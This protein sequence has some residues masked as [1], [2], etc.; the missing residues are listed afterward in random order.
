[1]HLLLTDRLT[2]P[3]CGPRFGLILRADRLDDRRVLEGVLGCPNCREAYPVRE[4]TGDLRPEPRSTVPDVPDPDPAADDE[5]MAARALLGLGAEIGLTSG[6]AQVVLT[7]GVAELAPGLAAHLEDLEVV[8]VSFGG[9]GVGS[10]SGERPWSRVLTTG[11][12]PF[13]E[14]SLRGVMM[15]GSEADRWLAAAV[16]VVAPRSRVV[17]L[18]PE[19]GVA[20]RLESAGLVLKLDAT[21]AVVAERS[22]AA[23]TLSPG[24]APLSGPR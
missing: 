13:H 9:R 15:R 6:V 19:A 18:D 2:C 23:P 11:A 20:S 4:G 8:V 24:V 14:A 16:R 17:V 1:V 7:E 5:V 12:L 22:P 10:G 3:R 21:E